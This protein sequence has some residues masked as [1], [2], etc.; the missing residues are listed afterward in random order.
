MPPPPEAGA[1]LVESKKTEE[2]GVRPE[3]RGF[4]PGL[5]HAVRLRRTR[6][7]VRRWHRSRNDHEFNGLLG[8]AWRSLLGR[9]RDWLR[10]P[11]RGGAQ[12][13]VPCRARGS[14]KGVR[15]RLRLASGETD[16]TGAA[17]DP[18]PEPAFFSRLL[19]ESPGE[20]RYVPRLARNRCCTGSTRSRTRASTSPGNPMG[21][22]SPSSS[23]G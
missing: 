21:S 14:W 19:A 3:T 5:R 6:H 13:P 15:P 17:S 10:S 7:R 23:A 1:R 11:A 8:P 16:R 4:H 9:P 20:L 12:V 18:V 22:T 2:R